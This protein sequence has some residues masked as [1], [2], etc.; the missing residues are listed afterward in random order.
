MQGRC[1]V[2]QRLYFNLTK[3]EAEQ[4][5]IKE[6]MDGGEYSFSSPILNVFH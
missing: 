6:S 3:F 2:D 1:L 5:E 4:A